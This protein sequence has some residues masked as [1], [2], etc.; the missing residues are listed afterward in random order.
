MGFYFLGRWVM[1]RA[2]PRKSGEISVASE[3][4]L[5]HAETNSM[6]FS[7]PNW[8]LYQ[9][10]QKELRYSLRQ[11]EVGATPEHSH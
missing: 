8:R 1:K 5:M 7:P 9:L 11:W 3:V 2:R 4:Q 10:T 6:I